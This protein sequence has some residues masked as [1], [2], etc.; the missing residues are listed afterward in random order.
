MDFPF[1]IPEGLHINFESNDVDFALADDQKTIS[2]LEQII[3]K[4]DGNVSE[5]N[6][7]FCSDEYFHKLNLEYLDHDTLTDIITF[8]IHA[9]PIQSDIFISIDRVRENASDRS[10]PFEDELYRV[11]AHGLLHLL[12]YGDKTEEDILSMRAKEYACLKLYAQ[13]NR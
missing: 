9:D 10:I 11:I 8:P 7:V 13:L 6:Y 1:P 2:W 4:E 3:R 5:L 12:G